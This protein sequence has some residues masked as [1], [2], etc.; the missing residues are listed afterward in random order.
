MHSQLPPETVTLLQDFQFERDSGSNRLQEIRTQQHHAWTYDEADRVQTDSDE[1]YNDED[2]ADRDENE[3]SDHSGDAN[4]FT[5]PDDAGAP[6]GVSSTTYTPLSIQDFPEDWNASQFWYT[7][8]TA[9]FYAK[10]LLHDITPDTNI[11]IVSTPSVYMALRNLLSTG[12]SHKSPIPAPKKITLLEF[13]HRFADVLD[14][15]EYVHYDFRYP[16]RL[17][18]GLKGFADRVICDPPFL[19]K[20]CQTAMSQTIRW[21]IKEPLQQMSKEVDDSNKQ[22]TTPPREGQTGSDDVNSLTS[23]PSTS[24]PSAPILANTIQPSPQPQIIISTGRLAEDYMLPLYSGWNPKIPDLRNTT[25]NPQHEQGRLTNEWGCYANFEVV[26][27]E[28]KEGGGDHG[29]K[30]LD[31]I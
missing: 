2:E 28:G 20:E 27:D 1:D 31:S 30:F 8:S 15:G 23:Q 18:K 10:V 6:I 7:S 26:I 9:T 14:G 5:G 11:V 22:S 3:P 17:P 12:Q 21:L 16:L 13:D 25:F 4:I 29:W 19:S 24:G